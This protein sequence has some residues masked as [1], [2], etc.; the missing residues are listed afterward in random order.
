VQ[1][2][3]LVRVKPGTTLR[4]EAGAEQ[5]ILDGEGIGRVILCLDGGPNTLITGLTIQ[6]GFG[7][8]WPGLALD[9]GGGI[10]AGAYDLKNDGPTISHCI[11]RE[12]T[13]PIYGFGGGIW[14]DLGKIVDCQVLNNSCD[15]GRGSG[16]RAFECEITRC[17]I[18]GN[19]GRRGLG[20]GIDALGCLIE[21][22]WIEGN[23]I[24]GSAGAAGGGVLITGDYGRPTTLRW[25]TF[26]GNRC[27]G[28]AS[29]GAG[30]GLY[31]YKE[32]VIEQCVFVANQAIG[33]GLASGLGAG[34]AESGLARLTIR[35]CTFI[36]NIAR[37]GSTS[38]GGLYVFSG[39]RVESSIIAA[40]EGL[41]CAGTASYQCVNIYG[42]SLG[43][44]LAG[45]DSGDNFSEEPQFC[46]VDP[47]VSMSF[48]LQ[49]D[50]PCAPGN[51][52]RPQCGLVG[53]RPVGCNQVPVG[54]RTWSE[55]KSL[56]R[57]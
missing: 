5:T 17:V 3:A 51:P 37:G 57:R 53:A 36:G 49:V 55:M 20:G 39:V 47:V 23:E 45:T 12:N 14:C 22:C 32:A 40:N 10:L 48:D 16:I 29:T 31:A 19:T 46:A 15:E 54:A 38:V 52:A 24:R 1:E 11:V 42:N 35:R 41:A 28:I 50:S 4:G 30:A 8:A 33:G 9:H 34:I 13:T 2:V 43:D 6:H 27:E 7:R 18:R 44:S 26:V 21:D 56:Y 25:C